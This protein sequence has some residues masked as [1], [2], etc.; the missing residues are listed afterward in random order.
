MIQMIATDNYASTYT[1]W[2]CSSLDKHI[3]K[4]KKHIVDFLNRSLEFENTF[5]CASSLQLSANKVKTQQYKLIERMKRMCQWKWRNE[6]GQWEEPKK[7]KKCKNTNYFRSRGHSDKVLHTIEET[8]LRWML[9][10]FLKRLN[11][12]LRL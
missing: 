9:N 12:A 4:H 7:K 2:Y 3:N 11:N 10:N 8:I 1:K 5:V 6:W